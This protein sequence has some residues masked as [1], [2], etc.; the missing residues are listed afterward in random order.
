M[1]ALALLAGLLGLLA[2]P[3]AASIG[4]D[5]VTVPVLGDKPTQA[6]VWYPANAPERPMPMGPYAQSAAPGAPV[7]GPGHPLIVISHGTGGGEFDHMDTAR[8]L[9][10]AGFVVAAITHT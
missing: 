6:A 9:A 3:A 2:G 10:E 5:T 1:K 8:A 7:A 4:F